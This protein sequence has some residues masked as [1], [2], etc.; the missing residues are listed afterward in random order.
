[1]VHGTHFE[2][3]FRGDTDRIGFY[4]TRAQEAVSAANL[5]IQGVFRLVFDQLSANGIK[6]TPE[7]AIEFVEMSELSEEDDRRFEG[8]TFY[9]MSGRWL[10]VISR[11]LRSK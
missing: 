2:G 11:L 6:R 1:M 8:F 3:D 4:A 10:R 5:D 9:R 7:S